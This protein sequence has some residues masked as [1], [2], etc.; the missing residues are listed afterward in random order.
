M[1]IK[2]SDL[3]EKCP[4][5]SWERPP[6]GLSALTEQLATMCSEHTARHKSLRAFVEAT[7]SNRTPY[8]PPVLDTR[9]RLL[10]H[11]GFYEAMCLVLEYIDDGAPR[12]SA[13]PTQPRR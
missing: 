9:E 4:P 7:Q 3:P 2:H 8:E 12:W 11:A 1:A 10:W 6:R 5:Q 13:A